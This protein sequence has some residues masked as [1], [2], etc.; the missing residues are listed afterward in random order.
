MRR[1]FLLSA[2]LLLAMPGAVQP[3]AAQASNPMIGQM[4]LVG[5][6]FC[7]RSWAEANGQ[8]LPIQSNTALFS[9]YGCTYGGDCRTSF[10]LPDLRGRVPTSFG[11]GPGLPEGRLGERIGAPNTT[12]TTAEMPGHNHQLLA[13]SSGPDADSPAN[14]LLATFNGVNIYAPGAAANAIMQSNAI[15]NTGGNQSF[16][17]YQPTLTLRYCIALQGI[18][19]SRN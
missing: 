14:A 3:A 18:F 10:A 2:S 4:I 11:Q 13:T 12:L 17:Q 6:T 9:L 7:P 19:P 5:F 15:G 1:A 16:P 8:L